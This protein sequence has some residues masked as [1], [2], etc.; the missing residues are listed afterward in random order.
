MIAFLYWCFLLV[1]L[2]WLLWKDV[3]DEWRWD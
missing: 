3:E 2:G 1:I